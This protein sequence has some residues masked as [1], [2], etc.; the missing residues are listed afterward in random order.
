MEEMRYVKTRFIEDAVLAKSLVDKLFDSFNV[1]YGNIEATCHHL[2]M[3]VNPNNTYECTAIDLPVLILADDPINERDTGDGIKFK[4]PT[5][6]IVGESP[7]RG[8]ALAGCSSIGV[9]FGQQDKKYKDKPRVYDHV[10]SWYLEHGFDVLITNMSKYRRYIQNSKGWTI[11][12]Q[13]EEDSMQAVEDLANELK[14]CN[15]VHIIFLGDSKE[16][17]FLYSKVT[18]LYPCD[19][20]IFPHPSGTNNKSWTTA[21][22]DG[23]KCTSVNKANRIVRGSNVLYLKDKEPHSSLEMLGIC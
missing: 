1:R 17:R 13:V 23:V 5:V 14:Q 6:A 7:A 4:N 21:L 18:E 20:T 11:T 19:C 12:D 9:T 8:H 3:T 2:N 22:G 10:I 15:T 16:K